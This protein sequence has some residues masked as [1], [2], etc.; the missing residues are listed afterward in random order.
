MACRHIA[1]KDCARNERFDGALEI[2]LQRTR[3]EHGVK[4]AVDD[5]LLCAVGDLKAE[6]LV[7]KAL[8]E[9]GGKDIN[10]TVKLRLGKRLEADDLVKAVEELR[11]ELLMQLSH[12]LLP[13]ALFDLALIVYAFKQILAA[14]VGGHDDNGVLEIDR[15]SLRIGDAAVVEDLQQDVENIRV[16]LFDLIKQYDGIRFSAHSLGKLTALVVADVS[17]RRADEP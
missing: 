6:A 16:R 15:A 3:A 13:C 17:G 14:E 9:R 8:P 7:L 2:S 5:K 10:D 11:P 4:A 1:C 12:D